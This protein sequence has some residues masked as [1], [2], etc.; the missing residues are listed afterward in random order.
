M[1][2]QE[3]KVFVQDTTATILAQNIKQDSGHVSFGKKANLFQIW[4]KD[5]EMKN[6]TNMADLMKQ[7]EAFEKPQN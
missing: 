4:W 6:T 7:V 5:R 3:E 1:T 2:Q